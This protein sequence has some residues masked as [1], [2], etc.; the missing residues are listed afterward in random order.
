MKNIFYI[1]VFLVTWAS[2]AQTA[3]Y[4]QAS[5]QFHDG[6]EVGF[7]TSF[8]NDA[9][10][11]QNL[12]AVG[13]YG[14]NFLNIDG[15][16]TPVFYDFEIDNDHGVFLSTSTS[17][18][19]NVTFTFG[20]IITN[21]TNPDITFTLLENA[22]YI[23]E[24][25]LSKVDGYMEVLNKN[26]YDFPVGEENKLRPI[27]VNSENINLINK[28]AYFFENPNSPVSFS[29]IFDTSD[30]DRQID[31]I[32]RA[33]FW[34]LEGSEN[35]TVIL[36]WDVDSNI[37]SLTD[38]L[39][40]LLVIG[41]SKE[42]QEWEIL[43]NTAVSGDVETIGSITSGAFI[44]DDYEVITF[45][46]LLVPQDRLTIPNFFLSPNGDG[47]N[48]ALVVEEMEDSADNELKIYNREGS[49]VFQQANY[50]NEFVGVANTNNFVIQKESGLPAGVYFYVINLYDL[51]YEFQGFLYLSQ[52]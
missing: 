34:S 7:H 33:E 40:N 22:N 48:D 41:F 51:G 49:L 26:S 17:V 14:S 16:V 12:G 38:V 32:S 19:N 36:S 25:S 1:F 13:F 50:T 31:G 4:H 28:A 23:G 8:I 20:D 44:P 24:S 47:I 39:E 43:G 10:F 52:E 42:N 11:D 9:P 3:M 45:G 15:S 35:S 37:T 5:M 27:I 46:S 30:A 6:S 18:E 21:K 29:K 2:T